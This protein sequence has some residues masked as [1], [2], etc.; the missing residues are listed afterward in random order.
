MRPPNLHQ[1]YITDYHSIA[2]YVLYSIYAKR[3][4]HTVYHSNLKTWFYIHIKQIYCTHN[5]DAWSWASWLLKPRSCSSKP[6]QKQSLGAYGSMIVYVRS[7]VMLSYHVLMLMRRR[8]KRGWW[9]ALYSEK[10]CHMISRFIAQLS[11]QFFST[12]PRAC[13]SIQPQ[14]SRKSV[15]QSQLQGIGIFLEEKLEGKKK[16]KFLENLFQPNGIKS[17]KLELSIHCTIRKQRALS[18]RSFFAFSHSHPFPKHTQERKSQATTFAALWLATSQCS[19]NLRLPHTVTMQTT[20]YKAIPC[21]EA[22]NTLAPPN[23]SD[24]SSQKHNDS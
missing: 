21:W 8:T 23:A 15:A 3:Y 22:N 1:L 2:V 19:M 12:T 20:N 10:G 5:S 6:Q 7:V 24:V 14:F 11:W 17:L 9:R 18:I 4:H 16:P 13:G